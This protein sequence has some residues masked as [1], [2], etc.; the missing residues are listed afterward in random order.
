MELTWIAQP[1]FW[2]AG[3]VLAALSLMGMALQKKPA[4]AVLTGMFNVVCGYLM[5]GAGAE[6]ILSQTAAYSASIAA[7]G[8]RHIV[9]A[10]NE[11]ALSVSFARYGGIALGILLVSCT[12]N[13]LLARYSRYKVVFFTCHV[14]LF[15]STMLAILL[16]ELTSWP[17]WVI[18]PAGGLIHLLYNLLSMQMCQR[19]IQPLLKGSSIALA[20]TA[21]PSLWISAH[22]ASRFGKKEDSAENWNIS[23]KWSFFR[24]ASIASAVTMTAVF[25]LL[26][27]SFPAAFRESPVQAFMQALKGGV[28]FG[29]A[30]TIILSGIRFITSDLTATL[31][32]CIN[33]LCPGAILGMDAPLFF[34][35]APKSW[36][37]SFL[38]AYPLSLVISAVLLKT[39]GLSCIAF[40]CSVPCFFDAGI[41]GVI[42][43]VKG[44][45]RGVILAAASHGL[46]MSVGLSLMASLL[47]VLQQAGAIWGGPDAALMGTAIAYLLKWIGGA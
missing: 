24:D 47:P 44:G 16:K 9:F 40:L 7:A 25:F 14:L 12:L 26:R 33:K 20:H 38:I 4:T 32:F 17:V 41:A 29:A 8:G 6:M 35:A 34:N 23:S 28:I 39:T 10:S 42:G 31:K 37:L 3:M 15:S 2:M 5:L 36:L 1:M 13:L 18:I 21:N 46:I 11:A 45:K 43:N 22:L 27:L 30:N 19:H